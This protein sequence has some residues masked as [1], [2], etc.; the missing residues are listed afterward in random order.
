[1]ETAVR[2]ALRY[3]DLEGQ[4]QRKNIIARENAYHGSTMLTANLSGIPPMAFAGTL[5]F[6]NI[7]HIP[8][9]YKY[10]HA[11]EMSDA[12]FAKQAAGWL[13]QK[14][15]ELG[16]DTVALFIAEPF[17]GAGGA[18][19]PPEGYWAEIQRICKR[20]DVL[21]AVDEVVCGFGRTG[22]WFGSDAFGI[23]GM[24]LMQMAKGITSAYAPLSATMVSDRLANTL[25]EKG[26]E[27][28]HGFTYS[29]H[30]VCCAVALENIRILKQEGIVDRVREE[31]GPHFAAHIQSLA[32]HPLVGNVRSRGL[33]G[34]IQLAKDKASH[35]LFAEEEPIGEMVSA[36]ALE[37]GL[38]LR[39]I[40]NTNALMP[41]LI[42]TKEQLDFVFDVARQALDEVA[43]R[44]GMM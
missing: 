35:T 5:P 39:D 14:I 11:P 21:L 43:T 1:N 8:A 20:Y 25:I 4:P 27:W 38:A 40:G 3:W 15:L 10:E 26:G 16:A 28:W 44:L 36:A 41:P 7:H 12:D 24:D 17:Q 2:L 30:P 33:F 6:P 29:G 13:E 32:D 19:I 31:T 42:I 9:P 18:I 34:G 22:H 37:K 23:D